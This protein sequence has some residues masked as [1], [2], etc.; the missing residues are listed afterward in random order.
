MSEP[1]SAYS[2]YHL[3][4]RVAKEAGIAYYGSAGSGKAV[5]PVDAEQ[6]QTV[7][8][9]VND[10]IKMFIEDAPPKGWRWMRRIAS[11][12]IDNTRI[13]GTADD[14]DGTSI[15]DLTLA[16]TYDADDDLNDYWCYILTGTGAGSYAQITDYT[17][18]TGKVT[19]ADWLDQYGNASGTDP[20]ATDTFAITQVETVAGD[21]ARY[22]LPTNFGGEVNGNIGYAADSNHGTVIDWVDESEIRASRASTVTSG[23][24][25]KAAI[26]PL[27]Y[28]SSAAQPGRR[29]ELIVDSEPGSED[30]LTFPYTLYFDNLRLEAAIATAADATSVTGGTLANLY[31]DDYFNDWIVTIMSGTGEKSYAS[32]T[33]YT[34]STGKVTVADWLKSDGTAGGIDP[35]ADSTFYMVPISNLHPAGFKFDRTVLAACLAEAEVKLED[36]TAGY[37]QMYMQKALPR[38]YAAD[39]RTAPRK[40]GSMNRRSLNRYN[41]HSNEW[42]DITYN[43]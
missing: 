28:A 26:R 17:T 41:A 37:V 43:G 38:A 10:G 12:N 22:P 19:V 23:Y 11:V 29:W 1:T 6:L 4:L 13:T 21:V 20:V 7:K 31:P 35:V 32:I 2:F 42:D 27:E 33:D 18:L 5:I 30:T 3:L 16:D 15:T 14:A 9:M 39:T 25:S 36:I 8:S 24:P 34:G 40:L